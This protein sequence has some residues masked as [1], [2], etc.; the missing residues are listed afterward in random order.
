MHDTQEDDPHDD[1]TL[2]AGNLLTKGTDSPE[3]LDKRNTYGAEQ[4]DV[5]R[6]KL[7]KEERQ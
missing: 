5:Q 2:W 3:H 1:C 4:S 6:K 7:S